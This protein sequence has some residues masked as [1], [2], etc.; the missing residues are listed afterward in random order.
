MMSK[1]DKDTTRKENYRAISPV[2]IIAKILNKIRTK[3]IQLHIKMIIHHN[4]VGYILRMQ[5]WFNMKINQCD[6]PHQQ[7]E[8]QKPHEHLR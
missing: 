5:G 6:I 2:T 1:S 8:G 3:Q 4:Q 7:N